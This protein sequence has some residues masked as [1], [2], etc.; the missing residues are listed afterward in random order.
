[1]HVGTW[2]EKGSKILAKSYHFVE[3]EI[4]F[5]GKI[6]GTILFI[7][8]RTRG[9]SGCSA[10]CQDE[11]ELEHPSVCQAARQWLLENPE[12]DYQEIRIDMI[13]LDW[14]GKITADPVL[15]YFPGAIPVSDRV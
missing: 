6:E 14:Y 2:C 3:C 11:M 7:I 9:P 4:D 15:R 1:M 5:I 8:V 10:R 13:R 12:I